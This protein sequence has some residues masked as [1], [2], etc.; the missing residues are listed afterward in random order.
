M[1]ISRNSK[2]FAYKVIVHTLVFLMIRGAPVAAQITAPAEKINYAGKDFWLA[3]NSFRQHSHEFFISGKADATINFE[4]T[5]DPSLNETHSY[6]AGTVLKV[7]ITNAQ[8]AAMAA[9]GMETI[10]NASMHISS[11][12]DV[13]IQFITWGS[14]SDD[15]LLIFPSNNQNY[16]NE[17]IINGFRHLAGSALNQ[18]GTYTIVATCNNVLLEITPSQNTGA[19]FAGVPF[20]LSMSQGDSYTFG[21]NSSNPIGDL[22][23]TRINILGSDCCNPINVFNTDD[24]TGMYWPVQ[25][26]ALI[27]CA[28]QLL[29]Q[30]LPVRVWDRVYPVVPFSNNP[31]SNI[32]IV[33]ATNSN[34]IYF[35]GTPVLFLN[36]GEGMDTVINKATVIS[37]DSALS[38]T[39]YMI[40][41]SEACS[42]PLPP[43]D[44]MS[45]PSALW[46]MPLR[47]GFR[48]SYFTTVGFM[49]PPPGGIGQPNPYNEM[50]A[51][52]LIS[53]AANINSIE[54][55]NVNIGLLF[56]PFPNDPNYMYTV[57]RPDTGIVYH[58]TSGERIIGYG[59]GG[60]IQGSSA[61][62]MGDVSSSDFVSAPL[63]NQVPDTV[64]GCV[65]GT[66][67]LDAGPADEYKW[68]TGA[69]TQ[70]ISV[71][72]PGY[73]SV[74]TRSYDT[75]AGFT[76]QL[77]VT[78]DSYAQVEIS[79][80]LLKCQK[81]VLTLQADAGADSYLWFDGS[82]AMQADV[83]A[84]GAAYHVLQTFQQQCM[85]LDHGFVVLPQAPGV[86]L[87]LGQDTVICRGD[88]MFITGAGDD[89]KWSDGSTGTRLLINGP[90]T[91]WAS[92]TDTCLG[93]VY[94]D[95]IIVT[96]TFCAD[97]YC[98][99]GFPNAFT[100]NGD[101]RNDMFRPV[102]YGQF[103]GYFI[104]IYNRWGEKLF[105]SYKI[106]E[107][108]DGMHKG[109]PAELGV[110]Y[111]LGSYECPIKGNV[112]IKGEVSLI[113]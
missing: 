53:S 82:T 111:Y 106:D 14:K 104:S 47:D 13:H 28:D 46:N 21:F 50:Q 73:F 81:E 101:G 5:A 11:D 27:C 1:T 112:T 98:T 78:M 60:A 70:Q 97:R 52:T 25:S 23:G 65:N 31:Y 103:T 63:L 66:V 85:Q 2:W 76:K 107:G 108:W 7:N 102:P 49:S 19:Q 62:I 44:S 77:W 59:Y 90:G 30:V 110:Y 29:E 71:T 74:M 84:F 88:R 105:H 72:G 38:V 61:W 40:S 68:S 83:T 109:E 100:P 45:D 18:Y 55:N 57:I 8:M 87:D 113:R 93:L 12:K 39:Q 24:I 96:D 91:Y 64:I 86:V 20:T 4:F 26:T 69:I 32:K 3:L 75:C 99:L 22:S 35:D 6:Q 89:T 15:G 51:V 67:V 16:G 9:P 95:T 10:S 43:V 17:Y 54:L 94:R 36:K 48:E 58:V 41:Q 79:D 37:G 56:L 34:T 80:T 42:N 33:S 92:I